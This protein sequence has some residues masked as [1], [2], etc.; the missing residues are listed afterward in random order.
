MLNYNFRRVSDSPLLADVGSKRTADTL[1]DRVAL[2]I[3]T[4]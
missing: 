3:L 1:L 4:Q 2:I